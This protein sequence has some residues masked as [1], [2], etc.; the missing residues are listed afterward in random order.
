MEL[1]QIINLSI[2]ILTFLGFGALIKMWWSDRIEK[3]KRQTATYKELEKAQK[4]EEMREV[5]SDEI[6][7]IKEEI[8]DLKEADIVK[9]EA[10][11]A[12]LRDRLYQLSRYCTSQ[13]GYTSWDDR[14]NSENMYQ[15]YH[16]LGENGVM[17]VVRD[18]FYELPT[19]EDVYMEGRNNDR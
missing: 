9:K 12:V 7:P 6:K 14:Q 13:K 1:Y 8:Q 16:T 17:D 15:K 19:E 2:T 4:Q 11:Q 10:I 18:K 3:K 5:I